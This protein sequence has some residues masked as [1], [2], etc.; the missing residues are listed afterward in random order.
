MSRFNLWEKLIKENDEVEEIDAELE[1]E[2]EAEE[3]ETTH[4][5]LVNFVMSLP[6]DSVPED[7]RSTYDTLMA[8]IGDEYLGAY[9]EE[10]EEIEDDGD[11]D[12]PKFDMEDDKEESEEDEEMKESKD[13]SSYGVILPSGTKIQVEDA[14]EQKRAKK[15][16]DAYVKVNPDV[17]DKAL[18]KLA[19]MAILMKGEMVKD[20]IKAY[21][22]ATSDK[23][24]DYVKAVKG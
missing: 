22:A 18:M 11:L 1:G 19:A 9:D 7:L 12:S 20:V 16:V 2:I 6:E 24:K 4:D 17:G 3:D 13:R 10:E 21:E 15:A 8:K 14:A 5:M 23:F